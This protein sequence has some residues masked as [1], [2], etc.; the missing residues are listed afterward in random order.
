M[1][2]LPETAKD[3][4]DAI[5]ERFVAAHGEQDSA[6]VRLL[7]VAVHLLADLLAAA[8]TKAAPRVKRDNVQP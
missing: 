7:G 8:T 2:L 3:Q 5:V 4:A 1:K 6:P